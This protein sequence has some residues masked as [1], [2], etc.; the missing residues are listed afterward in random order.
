MKPVV[1][2]NSVDAEFCL[3][4]Q[5]ILEAE[6][7]A[8]CLATRPDHV[9]RLAHHSGTRAI[10][11]DCSQDV[12]AICEGLKQ[13]GLDERVPI[14][15]LVGADSNYHIDLIE[16]GIDESLVRPLAPARLLH[17]LKAAAARN[18]SYEEGRERQLDIKVNPARQYAWCNGQ[19]LNLAPIGFRLL[20]HFVRFPDTV[21]SRPTLIAAAWRGTGRVNARTVDA[22]IARLRQ[23]LRSSSGHDAIRAIRSEG[24]MLEAGRYRAPPTVD[25]VA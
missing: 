12:R 9:L 19:Q 5:Y 13:N 14:A 15:A 24:Y 17:F 2:L 21:H 10:L 25:P 1:V 8:V 16:A 6:G 3:L 11:L 22:H 7:Y 23:A 18:S 20:Q 4:L